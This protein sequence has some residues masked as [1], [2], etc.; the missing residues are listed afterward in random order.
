MCEIVF[1]CNAWS[2]YLLF[3]F[4]LIMGHLLDPLIFIIPAGL[5][6]VT[7]DINKREEY[8]NHKRY[9]CLLRSSNFKNNKINRRKLGF[10]KSYKFVLTLSGLPHIGWDCKDD[11]KP[12]EYDGIMVKLNKSSTIDKDNA[13]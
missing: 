11:L 2:W 3:R 13:F 9:W 7:Q 1:I 8:I 6:P 4:F 12:S 10:L 5:R